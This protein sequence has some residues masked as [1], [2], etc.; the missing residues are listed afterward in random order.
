M[1]YLY[2]LIKIPTNLSY[3]EYVTKGQS[4]DQVSV[5]IANTE[6]N[7]NPP[8][9]QIKFLVQTNKMMGLNQIKI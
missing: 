5:T 8:I 6:I 9:I 4:V 1:N 7:Q 3:K 2:K